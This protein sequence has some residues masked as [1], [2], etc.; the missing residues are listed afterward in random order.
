MNHTY[1]GLESLFAYNKASMDDSV[2]FFRFGSSDFSGLKI[3]YCRIYEEVQKT[4]GPGDSLHYFLVSY[5]LKYFI[6][7][8]LDYFY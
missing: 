4:G 2:L 7:R 5:I 6:R 8:C 1:G 3:V